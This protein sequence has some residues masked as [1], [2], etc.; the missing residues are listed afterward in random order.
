MLPNVKHVGNK[1]VY[2]IKYK[3]GGSIERYKARLVGRSYNQIERLCFFLFYTFYL[4]AMLTTIRIH[5]EIASI[6]NWDYQ[7]DVNN[8]FMTKNASY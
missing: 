5:L 2:K 1:W 3:A 8:V 6:R 7:L 4:V